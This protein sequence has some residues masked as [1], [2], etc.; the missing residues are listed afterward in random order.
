MADGSSHKCIH[1]WLNNKCTQSAT[2]SIFIYNHRKFY[3][4]F[5]T[6]NNDH[7]SSGF[8]SFWT[9]WK[10]CILTKKED[11]SWGNINLPKSWISA[12]IDGQCHSYTWESAAWFPLATRSVITG[13]Q[14]SPQETTFLVTKTQCSITQDFVMTWQREVISRASKHGFEK[15]LHGIE[16]HERGE[17]CVVGDRLSLK[18]PSVCLHY[19]N[20]EWMM[21]LNLTPFW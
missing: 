20:R 12:T 17:V 15:Q 13:E 9:I 19:G 21:A 4:H 1:S 8:L 11:V 10:H 14:S 16:I 18:L 3:N 2:I 7:F 6:I 5:L